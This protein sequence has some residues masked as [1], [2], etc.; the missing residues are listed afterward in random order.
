MLETREPINTTLRIEEPDKLYPVMKAMASPE[1]LE[2]LNLLG[3]RSMNISELSEALRLPM[4]ST[5]MHVQQLEEVGLITTL[6]R[7]GTRG[8]IKLCSG[9]VRSLHIMFTPHGDSFHSAS[10]VAKYELPLGAYS[11]ASHICPTCGL[12]GTDGLIERYDIPAVFYHPSRLNAQVIWFREGF[13]EYRFAIPSCASIQWLELS[14]E[15]NP[16]TASYHA[17]W[18]SDVSVY[19]NDHKIGVWESIAERSVRRGFLT[20]TW[21]NTVNTQ[22]GELKVWRVNSQGSFLDSKRISD[23]SLSDLALEACDCVSV[24]IGIES[25]AEHIGGLVLFGQKFGDYEQ[26]ITLRV[27]YNGEES[28]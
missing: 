12:G 6:I 28:R 11:E 5:T 26:A 1:R 15:G 24:R 22:Y 17:P 2:I 8:N 9:C 20:P 10:K 19:I 27:G 18:E 7:P 16:Q 4:S 25:S 3:V 23:T 21:W 14:F 13:L